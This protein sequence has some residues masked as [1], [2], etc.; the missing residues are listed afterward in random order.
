[1]RDALSQLIWNGP[2]LRGSLPR[3][4]IGA[5]IAGLFV[6]GGVGFARGG[7]CGP[8]WGCGTGGKDPIAEKRKQHEEE[9]KNRKV[10]NKV[11]PTIDGKG[12]KE[13]EDRAAEATTNGHSGLTFEQTVL[14]KRVAALSARTA[15]ST[16]ISEP[17][18]A[19]PWHLG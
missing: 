14:A 15:W 4:L 12:G 8:K 13:D 19:K 5:L 11:V 7:G 16:A 2:R 10:S 18:R 1:M 6:G 3:T 9:A 17:S